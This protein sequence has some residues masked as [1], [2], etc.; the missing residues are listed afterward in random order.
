MAI[1]CAFAAPME[2]AAQ[3]WPDKPVRMVVPFPAGTSTDVAGRRIA[4]ALARDLGQP[5]VVENR[6]GAGGNLGADSVA[7]SAP[8]GYTLLLGTTGNLAVNKSL[9]RSL[10]YD[11][12]TDFTALTI[13]WYSCNVLVVSSTSPITGVATLISEA[14]ARPGALNYGS[15]GNGT[16]GHL[17][18]EWFKA[19][20]GTNLTHVP[21]KG[22]N[23]V[24]VDLI[25][26]QLQVSFE[27]VG[28]A[29]ALIRA[30][31]L[32]ALGSTCKDRLAVL[33]E[34]PTLTEVG[35]PDFDIRAW[36]LFA[37]PARLP[38]PITQ[39]L[40]AA[41]TKVLNEPAVRDPINAT[42]VQVATNSPAAAG[43]FLR[44][45]VTRWAKIVKTA[46]A[47]VD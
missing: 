42:G 2:V 21:Y 37:A 17:A 31:K 36:A 32:R 41:L 1:A 23:Q 5:V 16:A 12:I 45:E 20:T 8:D 24:I 6:A 47:V 19:M 14:K 43:A 46:G 15:P 38:E 11:P 30:G 10:P 35:V 13:A 27:A 4:E 22:G 44:D 33:P 18:G 3:T 34:L 26:G 9:F 25:A 40:A 29:I 39:R 28:N 7:K